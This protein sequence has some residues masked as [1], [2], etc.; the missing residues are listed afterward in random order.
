MTI[1]EQNEKNECMTQELISLASELVDTP[2]GIIIEHYLTLTAMKNGESQGAF[3][4][5]DEDGELEVIEYP[6]QFSL[7]DCIFQL[8]DINMS[9]PKGYDYAC[10]SLAGIWMSSEGEKQ[11][12]MEIPQALTQSTLLKWI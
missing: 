8:G 5:L 3:V 4:I 6:E 12:I 10:V 2:E 9:L 1:E 7:V 11:V